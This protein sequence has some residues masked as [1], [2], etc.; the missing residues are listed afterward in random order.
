MMFESMLS[1]THGVKKL[2]LDDVP[3]YSGANGW[4]NHPTRGWYNDSSSQMH[5]YNTGGYVTSSPTKSNLVFKPPMDLSRVVKISGVFTVHA[6][7]PNTGIGWVRFR[8][9]TELGSAT[10]GLVDGRT[11]S[12][13]GLGKQV[14]TNRYLEWVLDPDDEL[15]ELTLDCGWG[16]RYPKSLR[17]VKD[18]TIHYR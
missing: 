17:G 4:S 9:E 7:N 18:I 2:V 14:I 16:N 8:I 11:S 15:T 3:S 6:N 10:L 1:N 13:A 5:V 12:S